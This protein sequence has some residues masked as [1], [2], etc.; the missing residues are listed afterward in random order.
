M[1]WWRWCSSSDGYKWWPIYRCVCLCVMFSL[2]I[3][4]CWWWG[5]RLTLNPSVSAHQ[6]PRGIK[7]EKPN[8]RGKGTKTQRGALLTTIWWGASVYY[9]SSSRWP[10][11]I[12]IWCSVAL[13]SIILFYFSSTSCIIKDASVRRFCGIIRGFELRHNIHY[14]V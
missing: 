13:R 9:Y 3:W 7:R 12:I 14:S 8:A 6:V 10:Y 4:F 2:E 11:C 5:E 1:V